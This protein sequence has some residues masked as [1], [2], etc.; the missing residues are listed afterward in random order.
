VLEILK[1]TKKHLDKWTALFIVFYL[2]F[3]FFKYPSHKDN[4]S[5]IHDVT[6]YYGYLPAV[7]I[8]DN[9][10]FGFADTMPPGEPL[11]A[12]WYNSLPNGQR[13]QKMTMGLSYF[14]APSFFLADVY[15][16]RHPQ[17]NRNGF[18]KPYQ[19]A[20]GL[21]TLLI[22]I[23]SVFLM[24]LILRYFFTS[25]VAALV[26]LLIF[27]ATN[28]PYYI[29][30]APGL[31]H[32]YSFLLL[33]LQFLLVL[34]IKD[35]AQPFYFLL[36][37]L[38]T[39]WLVLIRPTN[40]LPALLPLFLFS[41]DELW[42]FTIKK[43]A[44]L[45]V[46]VLGALVPWLPQFMYWKHVSGQFLFYS[47]DTE[48]FFFNDPKIFEGLFGF[49]KGWFVYTPVMLA[50]VAGLFFKNDNY[51]I[52]RLKWFVAITLPFYLFVVFSWWCWWYGGSY[53]SRVMIEYYVVLAVFLGLV[54]RYF[55]QKKT[56]IKPAVVLLAV[57]CIGL[58]KSQLHQ[59]SVGLLHWDSMTWPAYR[60]I[61]LNTKLP[62]NY[63]KLLVTPDYEKAKKGMRD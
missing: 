55:F 9:I 56:V 47:Y 35:R 54:I 63:E 45:L 44:L 5:I 48:R 3:L 29:S 40:L 50:A 15:A 18:S 53:G 33:C 10:D 24:R 38:V 39:A 32:P 27:A 22:G 41:K 61:F 7:F 20:M 16:Q 28:L 30:M 13:F 52:S 2:I 21:N 58:T 25:T 23:M 42:A 6:S 19:W 17:F 37:G 26:L 46:L 36:I 49:R 1:N 60:A 51:L 14:Y 12:L 43:P 59:Y 11:D 57:F 31:S 4:R 8:Y 62:A 34:K